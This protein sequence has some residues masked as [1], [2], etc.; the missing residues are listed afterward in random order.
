MAHSLTILSWQEN[1]SADELP[2]EWMW[3]L[4]EELEEWFEDVMQARK[5]RFGDDDRDDTP[6]VRNDLAKV[7][8]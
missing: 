5:D 3:A 1:L 8:R 2:P 7:R 4:D 6:M